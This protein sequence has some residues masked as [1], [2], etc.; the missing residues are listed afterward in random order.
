MWKNY[1]KVYG[2]SSYT[3]EKHYNELLTSDSK[4]KKK[5]KKKRRKRDAEKED[6]DEE[7][8]RL[9]GSDGHNNRSTIAARRDVDDAV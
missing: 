4:K 2:F 5:K 7:E 6:E 3:L 1:E 8:D 9:L